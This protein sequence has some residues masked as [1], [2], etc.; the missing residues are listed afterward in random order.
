MYIIALNT[1]NDRAADVEITLPAEFR[2]AGQ[3]E[4]KFEAREVKVKDGRISDRFQP[5]ERHV[6]C[7]ER[8]P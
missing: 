7:I 6:Y 8:Q 1:D 4:V 2:Y 3:A 5:L